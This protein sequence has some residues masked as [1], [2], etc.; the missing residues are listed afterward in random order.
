M[1]NIMCYSTVL[2]QDSADGK[3]PLS[4]S[5]KSLSLNHL[6]GFYKNPVYLK[7]QAFLEDSVYYTTD[8]S[9]PT[10]QSFL[11]QDSIYL[12]FLYEKENMI[13]HITTS[14]EEFWSEPQTTIEKAHVLRFQAFRNGEAIGKTYTHSYFIDSLYDTKYAL[15]LISLVT[16]PNHFF[17]EDS[18]IYVPGK[19]FNPTNPLLSGN[20][21]QRGAEW[22]RPIHIEYFEHT[23]E[24]AFSQNAGAR[25]HGGVTRKL[26]QKTLRLYARSEYGT[27]EFN[28]PL[29][30][31]RHQTSYKRILLRSTMSAWNNGIISDVLAHQIIKDSELDYQEYQAVIVF[32]NGEYWGVHTLRDRIDERYIAY[33]HGV[34]KDSV[35]LIEGLNANI[36]SGSNKHFL[37]L[38]DFIA[39][40]DISTY[41]NYQ[42]VCSQ[43]DMNNYLD[44]MIAQVYFKNYDWPGNNVKAWKSQKEGSK[45]KWI[46]YDL[47]SGYGDMTY[48]MFDHLTANDPNITW[49][50]PPKSTF[51]FRQLLTN[52]QFKRDFVHRFEQMMHE[53]FEKEKALEVLD[54]VISHYSS[55]IPMHIKRWN[56]PKSYEQWLDIL[57][58]DLENFL[59]N[60]P[61]KMENQIASFFNLDKFNGSCELISLSETD[62]LILAPNP[63]TDF[64]FLYNNQDESISGKIEIF[65]MSGQKVFLE[66]SFKIAAFSK[67]YLPLH[68]LPSQAYIL[69]VY[70]N[71]MVKQWKLIINK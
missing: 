27:S 71:S 39:N 15:P 44:Y 3:S 13:S 6:S 56:F 12:D 61:C 2:A 70:S 37:D 1:T 28:Y 41:A 54:E 66:E 16:D 22:E 67:L 55:S 29:L 48:N 59:M 47:D 46:F 38:M 9:I 5:E 35:D 18:G 53:Y 24:L 20:Y 69:S 14:P 63:S 65:N 32:I 45:W 25:I 64:A 11:F 40:N 60:R 26:P 36:S 4:G 52:I 23:K 42:Y 51:L 57:E 33:L 30:P 49:P 50:N 8:G 7:V 17:H 43:M 62:V 19:L 34:N 58:M 21:Y 31:N 10:L 68:Q